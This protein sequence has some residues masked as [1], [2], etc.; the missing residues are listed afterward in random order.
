MWIYYSL[1]SIHWNTEDWDGLAFPTC[2]CKSDVEKG[3]FILWS[4]VKVSSTWLFPIT[5]KKVNQCEPCFELK[6]QVNWT[7]LLLLSC[8]VCW[9]KWFAQ[10][11]HK[12][13]TDM[14]II[15]I[16]LCLQPAR[17][18]VPWSSFSLM[19]ARINMI[20]K[21]K[22]KKLWTKCELTKE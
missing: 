7:E 2:H 14:L 13:D 12:I 3:G 20:K 15:C 19:L 8:S 6:N 10:R 18:S 21:R 16:P 5:E 1:Y 4:A 11:Y 22:E 17:P 9:L